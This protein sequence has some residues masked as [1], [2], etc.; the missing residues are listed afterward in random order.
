[1]KGAEANLEQG[2]IPQ[3]VGFMRRVVSIG[4]LNKE[5]ERMNS[6][7][8]AMHRIVLRVLHIGPISAVNESNAFYPPLETRNGYWSGGID[9]SMRE[10][11]KLRLCQFRLGVILNPRQA[12]PRFFE[13]TISVSPSNF[14]SVNHHTIDTRVVEKPY[15]ETEPFESCRTTSDFDQKY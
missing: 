9:V 5:A 8:P 15:G 7:G 1:M 10:L 4:L 12:G 2:Q 3:I 14:N 6:F 11:G 13:G